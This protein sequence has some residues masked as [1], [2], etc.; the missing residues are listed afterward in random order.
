MC[1]WKKTLACAMTCLILSAGISHASELAPKQQAAKERGIALHNQYRVSN[2]YLRIAAEAGDAEAQFFL[3][4]ELRQLSRFM[5]REAQQWVE[6]AANQ[7]HIYAMI[8]LSRSGANLCAVA[9]NCPEGSKTPRE[10]WQQAHDLTLPRAEQ[11]DPEALFM[12]YK[13]T[14]DVQ[15]RIKTVEAG[16]AQAQY[17]HAGF[18]NE[19]LGFYWLASS[20]RAE[21]ERLYKA[22]AEGGYPPGMEHHAGILRQKGDIAGSN[23]WLRKAAQ[24]GHASSIFGYAWTYLERY[25]ELDNEYDLIKAYGLISLLLEL[26]GGGSP[27]QGFA[28]I[29]LDELTEQ[30]Q[31]TPEQ[32]ARAQAF[33]EEWKANNPPLSFFPEILHPFDN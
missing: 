9:G 31:I 22:S 33:A 12:M 29:S 14:G 30:H 3:G 8:R 1:M 25:Q 16:H 10:W 27:N 24:T 26:D 32:A 5:T 11:G 4:E 2:S 7:G 17:L 20:R 18:V 6:A 13:L 15:W 23:H 19:G 21:V 28:Q